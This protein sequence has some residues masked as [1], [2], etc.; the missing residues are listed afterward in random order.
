M[1]LLLIPQ[2]IGLSAA[3]RLLETKARHFSEFAGLD[4]LPSTTDVPAVPHHCSAGITFEVLKL[5]WTV[6]Q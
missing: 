4:F 3:V 6:K 5:C 2:V 1:G